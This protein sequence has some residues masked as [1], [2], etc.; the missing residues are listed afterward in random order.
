MAVSHITKLFA[1][2]DAK[3]A[4]LLTDPAAGSATYAAS[5]SVPGIKELTVG[6]TLNVKELRG[7]NQQLDVQV[8]LSNVTATVSH[9]KMSLD[10]LAVMIGSSVTDSGTTPN[11]VATMTLLGGSTFSYFKLEGKTPTGGGDVP[12]GDV[13]WVLYK[14]ILNTFPALGLAEEDYRTASFGVNCVPRI[15]DS[16][17]LDGLINETAVAIA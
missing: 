12:G 10:A 16:K 4:K 17:I 1:V 3:L 6:G 14:C 5:I 15:A 9:A 11:A 13:H 7:S 8:T 2:S